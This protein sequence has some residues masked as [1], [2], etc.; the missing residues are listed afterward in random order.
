[1]TECPYPKTLETFET[2]IKPEP[3]YTVPLIEEGHSAL[4]KLTQKWALD[5][6]TGT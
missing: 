4:K 3:A 2:G 1:M 6:M 5:L